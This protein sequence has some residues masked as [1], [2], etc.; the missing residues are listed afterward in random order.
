MEAASEIS[1]EGMKS[2]VKH[3]CLISKKHEQREKSRQH[4][5]TQ[6]KKVK[7]VTL[8]QKP[9]KWLIEKELKELEK[10]MTIAIDNERKLIGMREADSNLIRQLKDEL[11]SLEYQLK[12]S[13]EL[14]KTEEEKNRALISDLTNSV[15]DLREKINNLVE[16]EERIKEL[17]KKVKKH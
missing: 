4:L 2:F 16:R 13:E 15:A 7:Q 9:R 17:E 5:D 6:F 10:K 8:T 11:F 1:P 12:E 14:R 3:L